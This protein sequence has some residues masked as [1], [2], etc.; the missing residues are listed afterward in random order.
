MPRVLIY[1]GLIDTLRGIFMP[2]TRDGNLPLG[3]ARPWIDAEILSAPPSGARVTPATALAQSAVY[4]CVRVLSESIASL[5]WLVYRRD[6]TGKTRA[7]NHALYPVLHDNANPEMPAFEWAE[8]VMYHLSLKGNHYSEIQMNNRGD[9]RA[10]WPLNPDKMT[11]WRNS[12]GELEYRYRLPNNTVQVMP[13]D[14]VF[15]ARGLSDNGITGLSPIAAARNAIGLALA[16]EEFGSRFFSNGARPS[17]ILTYP[18]KLS[19]KST[20]KI[21]DSFQTAY[22]GLINA[23]RV[24][25]LEEGMKLETI[26]IPP[27]DAQFLQT[28]KFQIEEIARMYRIPLHMVGVLDNAT[29]SNVEHLGMEFGVHTLRPWATRLEKSALRQL[30][31]EQERARFFTEFLMDGMLRGDTPSRYAAYAIG[32]QWGW[33]SADDVRAMENLND[34]PDDAGKKYLTPMNMTNA[35]QAGQPQPRAA[36]NALRSL[37]M[38]AAR[39]VEERTGNDRNVDK[40]GKWVEG[41][42]RPIVAAFGEADGSIVQTN[43]I[44][45][46]WFTTPDADAE[47]L[48]DKLMQ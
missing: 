43:S 38:D 20:D 14:I 34:L 44:A 16:T 45:A 40:H 32:R 9:I 8:L 35:A 15:H 3:D 27:E 18:G 31:S 12:N 11:V 30:F 17:A 33:L 7:I 46:W 23:Q 36:R 28:R 26:G 42:I 48:C 1:M 21:R 47:Q 29:F 4:A 13:P 39:R 24:A 2:Q 41:V 37:V 6:T 22:G 10:L 19:E 5:P 25:V